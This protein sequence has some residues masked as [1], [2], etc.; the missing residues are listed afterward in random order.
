MGDQA[1]GPRS[2]VLSQESPMKNMANP[3]FLNME[4]VHKANI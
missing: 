4:Q 2:D 3:M 1:M